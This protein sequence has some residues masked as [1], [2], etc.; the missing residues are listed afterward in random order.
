M[1]QIVRHRRRINGDSGAPEV[2]TSV[3]GEIAI[4][5]PGLP[6]SASLTPELWAFDGAVFRL[7]NPIN[8]LGYLPLSGGTITT[9][10]GED[11]EPAIS[12]V[13]TESVE[14]P[15]TNYKIAMDLGG[16][17]IDNGII[18]GGLF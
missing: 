6:G 15:V 14:Q 8:S 10:E 7:L 2:Q 4:N 13:L 17:A 9:V 1:A 16:G 12:F 3:P 5:F 11:G 18:D